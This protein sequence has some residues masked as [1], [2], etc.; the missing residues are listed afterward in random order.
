[1]IAL[2]V[3][4]EQRDYVADNVRSLAEAYLEPLAWPR[5]IYVDDEPVGSDAHVNDEAKEYF[6]WRFMIAAEHQGKGYGRSAL[7]LLVDEVRLRG[8]STLTASH[9]IGEHSPAGFY[10]AFGFVETGEV[11][12]DETVIKLQL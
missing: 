1:M 12:H 11:A 6:L 10:S 5:A 2:A 4:P 3:G 9:G 8:G 7:E